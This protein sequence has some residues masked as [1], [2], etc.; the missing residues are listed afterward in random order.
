M[1]AMS[2]KALIVDSTEGLCSP[3][4]V[5]PDQFFE[6]VSAGSRHHAE[7]RLMVAVLQDAVATFQRHVHTES[8]PGVRMFQEV[9]KWF[10][11]NDH[12]WPFSFENICNTL[13]INS[14]YLRR[15]LALSRRGSRNSPGAGADTEK[16]GRPCVRKL[17]NQVR[18]TRALAPG[19]LAAR[20]DGLPDR[21]SICCRRRAEEPWRW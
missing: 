12:S 8:G 19:A 10:W 21:R 1:I 20:I 7:K 5:L 14:L 6:R 11:S 16:V 4:I 3:V 18:E 17:S 2:Q 15:A 9:E 13:D